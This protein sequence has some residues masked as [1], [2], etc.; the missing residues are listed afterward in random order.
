MGPKTTIIANYGKISYGGTG[1]MHTLIERSGLKKRIDSLGYKGR[2]GP[3]IS[4]GEMS[5]LAAV[6]YR[7]CSESP[8]KKTALSQV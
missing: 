2:S 4:N 3:R 7:A 1:L 6:L 5:S 8:F